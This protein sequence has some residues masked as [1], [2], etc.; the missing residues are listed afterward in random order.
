MI[1]F[2][3]SYPPPASLAQE[4]QK[5]NGT[6]NKEDVVKRLK[7]DFYD[8]CY[9]CE[10]KGLQDPQ[11]EHLLPHKGGQFPERKFDWD[12][13]FWSCGHCNQV[14]NCTKYDDGIIDCCKVDPEQY[15]SIELSGSTVSAKALD[16]SN[17]V[18]VRTAMLIEEVFNLTNTGMRTVVCEERLKGL[19]REMNKLYRALEEYKKNPGC[20]KNRIRVLTKRQSAFAGFKRYYVRMRYPELQCLLD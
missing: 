1:H 3:R 14:K 17:V 10:L 7:D 8:K 5:A 13:L 16:A 15:L 4:A 9:I 18:A 20:N 19:Q 6:Y 2:E 11:V 12:N